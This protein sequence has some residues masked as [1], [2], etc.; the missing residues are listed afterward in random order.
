M[1][2]QTPYAGPDAAPGLP[3]DEALFRQLIEAPGAPGFE[4]E[5]RRVVKAALAGAAD[6][7]IRDRLGSLFGVLDGP[8]GGPTVMVA[9]HLDE[10]A[11]MVTEVTDDGL[12][13]VTAL[14]GFY[15]PVLLAQRVFVLGRNGAVPGVIGAPPPHG[16]SEEARREAPKLERMFVDVGAASREDVRAF[17]IR[18]GDPVVFPGVYTSLGGG[19]RV[20][21]KAWDNRFGVGLAIELLR[22]L[23][24]RPRVNTV[25]AGATVQEE[26]GLRG[27]ETAARLVRPDVF[28]ALD[29]GPAGDMPGGSGL[30]RLGGGVLMRVKDRTMV[31]HRR[32][33]DYLLDL[34]E[35]EGI[36]YQF[37]VSQGGTD[38]GRVHTMGIG[39][40][41]A[42]IGIP[43]RYIHS[44]VAIIDLDDYRA[45]KQL[46]IAAV[47]RLDRSTLEA[48]VG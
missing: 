10:V 35:T 13:K 24:D 1:N 22:A 32:L 25:I 16:L 21:A 44:P 30:G 42:V 41:S 34:A 43:A 37:F 9:G 28:F 19:R 40:P 12:L 29:A 47:S 17:G 5:V 3:Y 2:D 45:A 8:E 26:V 7:V 36:P 14:G 46:I 6:R 15:D 31:T 39:V 23:R 27:A 48:I 11:L 33:L 18:P 4:G 20:L 38:A